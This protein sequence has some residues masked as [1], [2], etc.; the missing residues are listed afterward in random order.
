VELCADRAATHESGYPA[1]LVDAMP[2]SLEILHKQVVFLVYAKL[3]VASALVAEKRIPGR[4]QSQ[5]LVEVQRF[6]AKVKP[7]V[8]ISQLFQ[9]LVRLDVLL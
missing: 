6:R 5:D 8:C 1:Q 7:P 2:S 9:G 4:Q 3:A